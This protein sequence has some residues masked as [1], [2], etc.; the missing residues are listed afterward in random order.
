MIDRRTFLGQAAPAALTLSLAGSAARAQ[1][2]ARVVIIGAG[3]GGT[4]LATYLRRLAPE[5]AVTLIE[6]NGQLATGA[7]TNHV[8]GGLRRIDQITHSYD[9]LKAGGVTLVQGVAVDVDVVRKSVALLDGTK[10]AYDRLVLA[11][12]VDFRF[13]AIE[14]YSRAAARIM[15]HAWRGADQTTLLKAQLDA[16]P[17]GGTVVMTIP[18]EPFSCPPA[19]YER[20]CMIAHALKTQK[21]RC[22]LIVLDANR[23]FPLQ[24]VFTSAFK[25][26]YGDVLEYVGTTETA[27]FDIR[28]VDVSTKLVTAHCG[29]GF[30]GG[31]V[32]LIAPQ[33]ASGIAQRAGCVEAGWCPVE[34]DTFMSA[35]VKEVH[36]IGDCAVAGEMP[37]TAFAANNQAKLL[38]A[39]LAQALAGRSGG[40]VRLRDAGWWFVTPNDCIKAGA[41][42]PVVG[43]SGGKPLAATDRYASQVSDD[44]AER[45]ANIDEANGWYAGITADML[46][47][48]G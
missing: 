13:D 24:E 20:A 25:T 48:A 19:A 15:P 17:D 21:V 7:F 43:K 39:H 3:S 1:T 8:L 26:Y 34:P 35:R 22:K 11:S 23:T 47:M 9:A 41:A 14:G 40:P 37:K 6:R 36:V 44:S 16:L 12:G 31:V 4:T 2:N 45:R 28:S 30:R 29:I 5:I 33:M 42:Y 27:T 46:G 10:V 18:P 38:A 32:N